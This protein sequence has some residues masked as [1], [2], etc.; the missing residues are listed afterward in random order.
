MHA[1]LH[2]GVVTLRIMRWLVINIPAVCG[3][4]GVSYNFC[5]AVWLTVVH[6]AGLCK[7]LQA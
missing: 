5:A 3:D 2:C 1:C 7:H 6:F 4:G